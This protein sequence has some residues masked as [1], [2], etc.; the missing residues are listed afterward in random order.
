[1][2]SAVVQRRLNQI[3]REELQYLVRR[4][5]SKFGSGEE[6]S[7][8][9]MESLA[10]AT[11]RRSSDDEE[12]VSSGEESDGERERRIAYL[13]TV[14]GLKCEDAERLALLGN[15]LRRQY[16]Q[17]TRGHTSPSDG[18]VAYGEQVCVRDME[19]ERGALIG[20]S[21]GSEN[22]GHKR[23]RL[24]DGVVV[25]GGLGPSAERH[26]HTATS[27]KPPPLL[28]HSLTPS[29]ALELS[30]LQA[31]ERLGGKLRQM[32]GPPGDACLYDVSDHHG[33][34]MGNH[35]SLMNLDATGQ[36][37]SIAGNNG[38]PL[39]RSKSVEGGLAG[40]T[41]GALSS[42][43]ELSPRKKRR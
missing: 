20:G 13:R 22:A 35:P 41:P 6:A 28:N 27:R 26:Q 17:Q 29:E 9:L 42:Q 21:G 30:M 25:A 2:Q 5:P 16:L 36:N 11:H 14:Y 32:R 43:G 24:E 33:Y 15:E 38:R 18:D 39:K 19:I 1:M 23:Q 40:E 3:V 10:S 34:G 31:V 4:Y 7:A 12:G 8:C 37:L